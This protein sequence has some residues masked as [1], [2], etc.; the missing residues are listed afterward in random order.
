M[1]LSIYR[2]DIEIHSK[3]LSPGVRERRVPE[4]HEWGGTK[5]EYEEAQA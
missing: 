1:T 5:A 4:L 3:A 2:N